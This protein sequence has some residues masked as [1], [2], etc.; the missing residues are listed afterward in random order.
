M[1]Y[2]L[3]NL[4]FLINTDMP[5]TLLCQRMGTSTF[6]RSACD[7]IT[8]VHPRVSLRGIVTVV[9]LCVLLCFL[10]LSFHLSTYPLIGSHC[11]NSYISEQ[12]SWQS[13]FFLFALSPTRPVASSQT[14][15]GAVGGGGGVG[16]RIWT[17][18]YKKRK[19][20]RPKFSRLLHSGFHPPG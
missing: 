15:A 4:L 10:Y 12:I 6:L 3:I 17:G 13:L 5:Q 1:A 2:I 11:S 8:R 20:G 16:T 19:F 7:S 14:E 9:I 18:N